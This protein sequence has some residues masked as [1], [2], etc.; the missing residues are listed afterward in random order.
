MSRESVPVTAAIRALRA[1]HVPFEARPYKYEPKGGTRASSQALGVDEHCVIKTLIMEDEAAQPLVILM[2]GDREV[3]TKALARHLGVKSV[4]PCAP[5]VAER[6]TGYQVGG[7]SPFGLRKPLPIYAEATIRDL[8]TLYING[9]RRGLLVQLTAQALAE[10][11]SPQW[12]EVA[13]T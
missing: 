7:T 9:G 11:L 10:A 2:H 8:G 3:S 13:T 6:H 4:Q 12:V 5:A 1:A